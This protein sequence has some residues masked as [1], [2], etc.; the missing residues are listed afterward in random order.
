MFR[1]SGPLTNLSQ[2]L[3][4]QVRAIE[5]SLMRLMIAAF[6]CGPY[7]PFEKMPYQA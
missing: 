3:P 2:Q 6:R 7:L 5:G 1:H 4:A